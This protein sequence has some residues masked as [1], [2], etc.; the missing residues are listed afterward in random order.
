VNILLNSDLAEICGI[1][2]GDGYMRKRSHSYEFELSGG[3]DEKEY[4]DLHVVPLFERYFNIKIKTQ[5]FKTKHTYGFR[6]CK[7]EVCEVLHACG[8]P[9]GK[10]TFVVEVPKQILESR[11]LDIIYSFLR[12]V[13]DTDGC[14]SFKKRN[15]SGYREFLIKRHTSPEISI[16]LCSK[17]LR[18][19]IAKLL[20]KTGFTFFNELCKNLF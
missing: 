15:G 10:K 14:F 20:S 9:Y 19:G 8:F 6:I 5:Y 4:Y 18:D 16:K 12:G 2:A 17:P 1:H 7:K 3:F 11:N 13:F